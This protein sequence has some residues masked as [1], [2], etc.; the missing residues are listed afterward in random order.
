MNRMRLRLLGIVLA[1][2][3][4]LALTS[5]SST[6]HAASPTTSPSAAVTATA[7]TWVHTWDYTGGGVT[8]QY[9]Y[10]GFTRTSYYHS[11]T[12]SE[13]KIVFWVTGNFATYYRHSGS[14]SCAGL[15]WNLVWTSPKAGS[16][17]SLNW[18]R[19][20]NLVLRNSSGTAVW[21]S[22]TKHCPPDGCTTERQTLFNSGHWTLDFYQLCCF[23]QNERYY[24]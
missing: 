17:S 8:T 5:A 3:S 2:L 14:S 6:S 12:C 4:V 18:Q 24:P 22:G 20:E 15:A 23:W 10:S 19:D 13:G 7:Y 21:A 9:S 1:T 16:N 11:S